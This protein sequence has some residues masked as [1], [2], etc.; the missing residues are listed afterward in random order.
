MEVIVDHLDGVRFAI[1]ARNH[2]LICDQPVEN[3][4][5]NS[6]MTPPEFLLASLGSCAAYYA[7]EYL[8]ARLLPDEGLTVKVHA[9]KA[10]SPARLDC[11]QIAVRVP[12]VTEARH[13][14]GIKT[15]VE[16]CLI[17]N[18]LLKPPSIQV[19]VAGKVGLADALHGPADESKLMHA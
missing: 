18:T 13:I 19:S 9:E 16:R 12:H 2:Q 4:G 3:G 17:H 15:S 10:T 14:A 7:E 1:T 8:R 11:F 6:G 5:T